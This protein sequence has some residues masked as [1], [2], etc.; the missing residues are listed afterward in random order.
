MEFL[1]TN[2]IDRKYSDQLSNMKW[3]DE[4]YDWEQTNLIDRSII[5]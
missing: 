3:N 5:Y 1:F 4:E 2:M